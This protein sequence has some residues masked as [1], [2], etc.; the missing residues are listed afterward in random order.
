MGML[1]NTLVEYI[2]AVSH[3]K[4]GHWMKSRIQ[5][6]CEV[7]DVVISEISGHSQASGTMCNLYLV[8]NQLDTTIAAPAS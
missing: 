4:G 7:V 1:S 8:G 3:R 2:E 6:N 5:G